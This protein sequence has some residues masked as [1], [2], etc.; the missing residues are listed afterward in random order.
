SN[1]LPHCT[2]FI[3]E[4]SFGTQYT[5][6]P[7]DPGYIASKAGQLVWYG[8][9]R[10]VNGDLVANTYGN[11][12]QTLLPVPS[13]GYPWGL[14]EPEYWTRV[15]GTWPGG[16]AP[17]HPLDPALVHG[18]ALNAADD[19]GKPITSYFGYDDPTFNPDM[20]APLGTAAPDGKLD[21]PGDS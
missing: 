10:G 21:S 13:S 15:D 19:P 6:N 12:I 1:F 20:D 14:I 17:S 7:T 4:W 16:T 2:E 5:S 9:P 18:S 3:V 11:P 8:M